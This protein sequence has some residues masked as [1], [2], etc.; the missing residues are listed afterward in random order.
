MPETTLPRLGN[1]LPLI[2]NS[3]SDIRLDLLTFGSENEIPE[4]ASRIMSTG[5]AVRVKS[6]DSCHPTEFL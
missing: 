2:S 4:A 3:S 1:I 5:V 6:T